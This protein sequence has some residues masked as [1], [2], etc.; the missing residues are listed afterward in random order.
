[1]SSWSAR[2]YSNL[3]DKLL[4]PFAGSWGFSF[5]AWIK[6]MVNF[7]WLVCR[8]WILLLYPWTEVIVSLSGTDFVVIDVYGLLEVFEGCF[9][10]GCFAVTGLSFTYPDFFCEFFTELGSSFRLAYGAYLMVWLLAIEF[11]FIWRSSSFKCMFGTTFFSYS[12]TASFF[13]LFFCDWFLPGCF[14]GCID[15]ILNSLVCVFC[16]SSKLYRLYSR[17]IARSWLPLLFLLATGF[18]FF[19]HLAEVS[20]FASLPLLAEVSVFVSVL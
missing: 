19:P 12:F 3:V 11:C 5:I 1:M 10:D 17:F 16:L 13:Y 9:F 14:V 18:W 7:E 8:L 2:S 6:F 20:S 15:D 4:Y